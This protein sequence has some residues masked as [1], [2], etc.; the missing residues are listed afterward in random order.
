MS[1][2]GSQPP[3]YLGVAVVALEDNLKSV[4]IEIPH[5]DIKNLSPSRL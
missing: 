4:M 5:M 1:C 2:A 3:V